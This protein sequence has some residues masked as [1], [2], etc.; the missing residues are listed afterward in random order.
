MGSEALRN[1]GWGILH[2]KI[3]KVATAVGY[4]KREQIAST[5][6]ALAHLSFLLS[7]PKEFIHMLLPKKEVRLLQNNY[8]GWSNFASVV[9]RAVS[10]SLKLLPF[11]Y[12]DNV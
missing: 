1:D 5:R 7:H 12:I 2:P 4:E 9:Y 3:N 8:A 6:M 10:N 11:P